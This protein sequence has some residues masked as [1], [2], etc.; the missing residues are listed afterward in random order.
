MGGLI[1]PCA[2][3]LA[4]LLLGAGLLPS[5]ASAQRAFIT[6]WETTS[7]SES[8]SISTDDMTG[9]SDNFDI[10]WG[11]GSAIETYAGSD[12]DPSDTY[13][14]VGTCTV[15]ITETFPYLFL[16]A[17]SSGSGDSN[18]A[19]KLQTMEQWG[20][21][22][23]ESMDSA[24]DG[25]ENMTSNA[26][27]QPDLSDGTST[28]EMFRGALAFNGDIGGWNVSNVTDMGTMF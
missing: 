16:D 25:A 24:F 21:I 23:W 18:N 28:H 17:T 15:E 2:M 27:D 20:D 6:T 5:P 13:S 8:I 4:T 19:L 11:D 12:P 26:T 22:Q 3:V 9:V 10:D 7:S 14:S 1:P